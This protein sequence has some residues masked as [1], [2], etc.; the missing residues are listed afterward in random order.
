L[1]RD[2]NLEGLVKILYI[3][4]KSE[5][6][7]HCRSTTL[8]GTDLVNLILSSEVGV[9]PFRH[10]IHHREF[11]PDDI[12]IRETDLATMSNAKVGTMDT[13]TA[14]AFGRVDQIFEKRRLLTGHLFFLPNLKRWSLFYFDQRD[15]SARRNHWEHG[16]HLHVVTHLWPSWTSKSVW[17]EF[18]SGNPQISGA[19][20][21]RFL[22]RDYAP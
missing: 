16:P 8:Y 14:K 7:K 11:I 3:E 1:Q 21:V 2:K 15:T 20:H 17:R 18:T 6:V 5:L 4:K 13:Q 10:E 12:Q 9:F 22:S 19:L